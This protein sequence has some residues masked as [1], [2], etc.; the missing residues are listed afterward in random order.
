M[1]SQ[2]KTDTVIIYKHLQLD[3]K[4]IISAVARFPEEAN[5]VEL[6]LSDW[7]INAFESLNGSFYFRFVLAGRDD[8]N[9]KWKLA[10]CS[11]N[12]KKSRRE[13]VSCGRKHISATKNESEYK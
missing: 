11:C 2:T 10:D 5:G 7:H 9:I 1:G 13:D 6:R 4:C 8:L 12:V 3:C